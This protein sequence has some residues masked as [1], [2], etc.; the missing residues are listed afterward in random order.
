MT[1]KT[2]RRKKKPP[3]AQTPNEVAAPEQRPRAHDDALRWAFEQL[4]ID[5]ECRRLGYRPG[6]GIEAQV[7]DALAVLAKRVLRSRATRVQLELLASRDASGSAQDRAA[8]VRAQ[9]I[10]HATRVGGTRVIPR[11][12]ANVIGKRLISE[13]QDHVRRT[14][15]E[16]LVEQL[17][18]PPSDSRPVL[19]QFVDRERID[20]FL[21]E[22]PKLPPQALADYAA[23]HKLNSIA[24]KYDIDPRTLRRWFGKA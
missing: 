4:V 20:Q 23:G 11:L 5:H 9:I 21:R 24:A 18:K 2:P 22:H 3:P 1:T 7:E 19:E 17:P 8:I 6:P 15:R 10:E 16:V 14:G 13:N 12:M